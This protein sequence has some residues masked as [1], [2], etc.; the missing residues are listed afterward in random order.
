[1]ASTARVWSVLFLITVLLWAPSARSQTASTTASE[2][3]APSASTPPPAPRAKPEKSAAPKAEPAPAAPAPSKAEDVVPDPD[4]PSTPR[5]A[6]AAFL[7]AAERNDFAAASELLDLRSLPRNRDPREA[8]ELAS[9]LYRV[10]ALRISFDAEALP[11]DP[12]PK[13]A[14]PEGVILDVAEVDG[15][16]INLALVPVKQPSGEVRWQFSRATVGAIRAIYDA[17]ERLAVEERVP[18]WL[19]RKRHF[20]LFAWQW[21]GFLVLGSLA[22]AIGRGVGSLTFAFL[23]RLA[24]PFSRTASDAAASLERPAR[25]ALA[26]TAFNGM[27]PYLLLPHSLARGVESATTTLYITATAWA[28]VAVVHVLTSSW[29]RRLP[30][31]TV[32]DLE[33]RGLRTR[34]T[35]LRRIASVIVGLVASGVALLQF[36]VVRSVGVSLLASAGIAGVLVGIAAQRTLG[37][38]IAGIEMS[39]TQPLRIGDVVVFRAQEFGTVEEIFFTYIIVRLWDDRRLIVPVTRVMSEPFENWT[40][41]DARVLSA[42]EIFVDYAAPIDRFRERFRELCEANDKWDGRVCRVEVIE[43]TDK[44]LKVRGLASVDVATKAVDLRNE[45]REGWITF[46]QGHDNGVYMPTG[47]VESMDR[48]KPLPADSVARAGDPS[49]GLTQAGE[50]PAPESI[51]S[52][53]L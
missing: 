41:T 11:D 47:R 20:G 30:E 5:R 4:A 22:Y 13:S 28:V 1:M 38:I 9:M 50:R 48:H 52:P 29:E 49:E 45:L 2:S 40:R 7:R 37:G 24:K 15:K 32:G 21:L 43:A 44:A 46:L 31:D 53:Q 16:T 23:R 36:E 33:S 14:G 17:N 27:E 34:L 19:K 39:I 42:V 18:S 26:V 3:A 35:M 25:L 6:F 10:L 8:N 12:V 51:K